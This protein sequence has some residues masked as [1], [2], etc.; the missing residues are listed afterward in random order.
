MITLDEFKAF[1]G[2]RRPGTPASPATGTLT[3]TRKSGITG[4]VFVF[5]NVVFRASGQ[6]FIPASVMSPT[7]NPVAK[8]R[9]GINFITLNVKADQTGPSG[10]IEASQ[11]WITNLDVDYEVS[12]DNAFIGGADE[13]A[14]KPGIYQFNGTTEELVADDRLQACLNTGQAAVMALMGVDDEDFDHQLLKEAVFLIAMY[15]LENNTSQ[16]IAYQN[17]PPGVQAPNTQKRFKDHVYG[18]LLLQVEHLISQSGKRN[19]ELLFS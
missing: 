13:V 10:N 1:L 14:D 7:Q 15:R 5:G 6:S 2:Y 18:P 4:D 19:I 11:T 16:D 8:I 9:D 12:N 17:S 3:L